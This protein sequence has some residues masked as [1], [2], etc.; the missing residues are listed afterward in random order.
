M[1]GLLLG[2]LAY[3][4]YNSN[5]QVVTNTQ[6]IEKQEQELIEV[7]STLPNLSTEDKVKDLEKLVEKLVKE[8]NS[9]KTSSPKSTN[10]S[11]V[12]VT[13][14]ETTIAELKLKVAALE[15]TTPTTTSS[16]G[17]SIYIPLGSGGQWS[18]VEWTTLSEYEVSLDPANFPNYTG[19]T[20][21]VVFR[22][23]DPAST[24]SVRLYNV[25]DSLAASLQVD[26]TST[27]FASKSSASF[28]LATGTKTYRLQVKSS[29]GKNLIIQTAR[30]KVSF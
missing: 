9:L 5:K 4:R 10:T 24:G 2:G 25:S 15:K 27:T 28:K 30:I 3:L 23:D 18:N 12:R 8:V 11:D 29:G 17:S 6:S 1:I 19:M 16:S 7:P 13:S 21:E 20:L 14:L 26:T 22:L